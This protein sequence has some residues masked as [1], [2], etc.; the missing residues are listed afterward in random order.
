M[1]WD[2]HPLALGATPAQVFI[3]GIAQIA[4][5]AV[6]SKPRAFQHAPKTPNF[7]DEAKAALKYDGLPPLEIKNK[8]ADTVVFDNVASV[9]LRTQDGVQRSVVARDDSPGVVVTHQGKVVCTGKR[10]ACTA[11]LGETHTTVDLQGGSISPSLVSYGSPLGLEHI[12]QE[13]STNDGYAPAPLLKAVPKIL[14]GDSAL[15]RAVDG[16]EFTTRDAL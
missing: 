1:I 11:G 16:L 14:G 8:H 3:D 13:S 10:E 9:Y 6:V 2:S 7:D 12:A 5:P 15:V 4:S